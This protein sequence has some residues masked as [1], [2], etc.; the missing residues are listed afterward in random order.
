MCNF[1]GISELTACSLCSTDSCICSCS[2]YSF[3]QGPSL[4]AS[5]TRSSK[6]GVGKFAA[7]C[8]IVLPSCPGSAVF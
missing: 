3:R 5:L 6:A 4:P 7:V 8:D 2:C 1:E